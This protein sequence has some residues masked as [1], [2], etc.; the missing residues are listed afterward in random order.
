MEPNDVASEIR[1]KTMHSSIFGGDT[2]RTQS[3]RPVQAPSH[4]PIQRSNQPRRL[5]ESGHSV[6]VSSAGKTRR[7]REFAGTPVR[8]IPIHRFDDLVVKSNIPPLGPLPTFNAE[9]TVVDLDLSFPSRPSSCYQESKRLRVTTSHDIRSIGDE[10][11]SLSARTSVQKRTGDIREINWY[12]N[13]S[14][15]EFVIE[16]LVNVPCIFRRSALWNI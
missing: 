6:S 8:K 13:E 14:E 1:R 4:S 12:F 10:I 7:N 11:T 15:V 2:P 9:P 5:P 16:R 3:E